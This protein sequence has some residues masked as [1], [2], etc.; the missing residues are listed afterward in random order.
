[1]KLFLTLIY[2]VAGFTSS[3]LSYR[4]FLKYNT[5]TKLLSPKVKPTT[6]KLINVPKIFKMKHENRNQMK[7]LRLNRFQEFHLRNRGF[8]YTA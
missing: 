3:Y 5:L 4:S 1:M 8:K 2:S 6:I 7:N